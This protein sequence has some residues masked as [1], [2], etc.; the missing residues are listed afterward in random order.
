MNLKFRTICENCE[1]SKVDEQGFRD[2]YSN[3][4]I[5]VEN[6][7]KQKTNYQ[8]YFC[9]IIDSKDLYY[10]T[11]IFPEIKNLSFCNAHTQVINIANNLKNKKMYKNIL[12]Y[13]RISKQ[14]LP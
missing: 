10:I 1:Y 11:S 14:F 4:K 9:L 5:I 7:K 8:Q 2:C 3:P 6:L 13:A 12:R